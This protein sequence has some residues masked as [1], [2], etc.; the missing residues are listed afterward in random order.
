MY[1]FDL[2]GYEILIDFIEKHNLYR[3]EGHILEIGSFLGGGTVKLAASSMKHG[4]TV[5]TV[6][7]FEPDFDVTV[8]TEGYSMKDIYN[9]ILQGKK[10]KHIFYKIIEGFSNIKVIHKDSKDLKF[11]QEE[12]FFFTFIDGNHSSFYLWNDFKLAWN[13]TVPEGVVSFHDYRGDLTET[14]EAIDGIIDKYREEILKKEENHDK[15]IL[16]LFKGFHNE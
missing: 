3:L 9:F 6:D 11:S 10:Q 7:I 8:N 14:T 5:Y 2:V 12:K 13:N 16:F 1:N 4:R 15:K